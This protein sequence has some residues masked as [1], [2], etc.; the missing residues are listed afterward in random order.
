MVY[1]TVSKNRSHLYC[2]EGDIQRS[3]SFQEERSQQ[4]HSLIVIYLI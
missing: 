3:Y 1:E 2:R 4:W